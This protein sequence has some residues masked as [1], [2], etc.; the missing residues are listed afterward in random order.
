MSEIVDE[1][2]SLVIVDLRT[3]DASASNVISFYLHLSN[4]YLTLPLI[5]NCY[6]QPLLPAYHLVIIQIGHVAFRYGDRPV[7]HRYCRSRKA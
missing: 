7:S 3:C 2:I 6:K 5:N 1:D 4:S